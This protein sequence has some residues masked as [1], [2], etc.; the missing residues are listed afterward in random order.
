MHINPTEFRELI[1]PTPQGKPAGDFQLSDVLCLI[2]RR[3]L[4]VDAAQ[5][6]KQASASPA[7][8]PAASPEVEAVHSDAKPMAIATAA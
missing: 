7:S 1:S 4:P 6:P 8:D 2:R 5:V 3:T